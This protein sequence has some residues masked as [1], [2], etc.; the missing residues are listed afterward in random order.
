LRALFFHSVL[1]KGG[2]A[3]LL[4]CLPVFF[5][6]LIFIRSFAQVQFSAKALGSNL[7]GAVVGGLLESLSFWIG[8]KWLLLV[9]A[10]L[11]AASAITLRVKAAQPTAAA[12]ALAGVG[13]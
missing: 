8:L 6:G 10:A 9:A 5:A 12:A 1:L 3:V 7:F 11:Y 4:L 13:K 2:A